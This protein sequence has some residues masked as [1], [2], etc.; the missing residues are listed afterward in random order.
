MKYYEFGPSDEYSEEMPALRFAQGQCGPAGELSTAD[1]E[2][3]LTPAPDRV[4]FDPRASCENFDSYGALIYSAAGVLVPLGLIQPLNAIVDGAIQWTPSKIRAQ[5]RHS[6][7]HAL[8]VPRN[9]FRAIYMQRTQTV[10]MPGGARL[11]IHPYW[12]RLDALEG[13]SVCRVELGPIV[14]S[15]DVADLLSSTPNIVVT[16]CRA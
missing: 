9:R 3:E 15:R 16:E 8:L 10:P 11:P 7:A 6:E 14:V 13:K 1:L 12:Y 2:I 4:I 5:E